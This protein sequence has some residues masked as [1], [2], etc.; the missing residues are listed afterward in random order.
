MGGREVIGGN[1]QNLI[2]GVVCRRPIQ[3]EVTICDFKK[4]VT[5]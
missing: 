2:Q 4:E 5:L 3:L 1:L